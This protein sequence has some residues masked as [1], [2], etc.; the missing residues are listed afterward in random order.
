M[1]VNV[2]FRNAGTLFESYEQ[3]MAELAG[4]ATRGPHIAVTIIPSR[5]QPTY[6]NITSAGALG[7]WGNVAVDLP[8][9]LLDGVFRN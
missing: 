9:N 7:R 6:I 1:A 8:G 4:Q 3:V 2:Y 5:A